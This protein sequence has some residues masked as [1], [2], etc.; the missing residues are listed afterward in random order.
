MTMQRASV[1]M[2]LSMHLNN[3]YTV[4]R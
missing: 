3:I 2:N 1:G 4:H